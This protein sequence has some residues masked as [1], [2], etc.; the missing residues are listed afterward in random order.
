[1]SN[2]QTCQY[3]A[4]FTL[5]DI[6]KNLPENVLRD[7]AQQCPKN[8]SGKTLKSNIEWV[9]LLFKNLSAQHTRRGIQVASLFWKLTRTKEE[10]TKQIEQLQKC[11]M[12]A[13]RVAQ[14]TGNP[15]ELRQWFKEMV[16]IIQQGKQSKDPEIR[17]RVSELLDKLCATCMICMDKQPIPAKC[18][19]CCKQII[20][21]T[22]KTKWIHSQRQLNPYRYDADQKCTC[23]AC[24]T[25]VA[26][27]FVLGDFLI[28]NSTWT[29]FWKEMIRKSHTGEESQDNSIG[30][31]SDNK[32]WNWTDMKQMY[33]GKSPIV[34]DDESISVCK[35]STPDK[36]YK[37]CWV[38]SLETRDYTILQGPIPVSSVY[39][40][41]NQNRLFR[42]K[43][44]W[45]WRFK[46]NG[47]KSPI[48][49]FAENLDEF[50]KTLDSINNKNTKFP[51]MVIH[52]HVKRVKHRKRDRESDQNEDSEISLPK[53]KLNIE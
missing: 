26:D 38:P 16:E 31:A 2:S 10:F 9:K 50:E 44:Q 33:P 52:K 21:E 28:S 22:C 43:I 37:H 32:E 36:K 23:P 35:I 27:G 11:A 24:R 14:E 8:I 34:V 48:G 25:S 45:L 4:P 6:L 42:G 46:D 53:K 40:S 51:E 29:E 13:S 1:M 47:K 39:F 5:L 18:T 17:A 3:F 15:Q 19:K 41:G 12:K 7:V 30:S 20:C 49:F